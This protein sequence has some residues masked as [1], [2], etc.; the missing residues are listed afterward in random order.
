MA[1]ASTEGEPPACPLEIKLIGWADPGKARA[2]FETPT[3][4][5]QVK[6]L[7]RRE[8]PAIVIVAEDYRGSWLKVK[9]K[10]P[11]AAL[12]EP[13][14][15]FAI[16]AR[17]TSRIDSGILIMHGD[18]RTGIHSD[19]RKAVQRLDPRL[20]YKGWVILLVRFEGGTEKL[21]RVEV[22]PE[23]WRWLR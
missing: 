15:F 14:A 11:C 3:I 18:P 5:G 10:T 19:T 12:L 9:V 7:M 16:T 22:N 4:G 21:N 1:S 13:G 8:Q 17:G 20:A 2:R 23:R 6:D